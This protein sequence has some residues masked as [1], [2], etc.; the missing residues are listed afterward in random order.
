LSCKRTADS[1]VGRY[2]LASSMRLRP[3]LQTTGLV[4][5]LAG[6]AVAVMVSLANPDP[7]RSAMEAAL[8][9]VI[10]QY[11]TRSLKSLSNEELVDAIT[12]CLDGKRGHDFIRVFDHASDALLVRHQ[13]MSGI[14]I[15]GNVAA[16]AGVLLFMFA[17]TTIHRRE[18]LEY[19]GDAQ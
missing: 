2:F 18:S 10:D 16:L 11:D 17:T 5:L 15:G 3:V 8:V 13:R 7:F 6:G 9:S 19:T 14:V 12:Q 4:L 1:G